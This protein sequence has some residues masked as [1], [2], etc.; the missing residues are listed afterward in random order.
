MNYKPRQGDIIWLN[1]NPQA[2]AEQSGHRPVIVVS[3]DEFHKRI[4]NLVMIC[5]I[6]NTDR[7]FPTHIRLNNNRTKTS[8]V[9]KCEQAKILD[10]KE[11]HAS[12]IE[13]APKDI[14][15]EAKDLVTSFIE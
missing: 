9:I 14:L 2:G 13:T 8:G 3:N 4:A 10:H 11:R 6:T 1:L 7:N 15:D 5:P 12:F